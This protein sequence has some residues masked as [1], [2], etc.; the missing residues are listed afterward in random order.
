MAK[1]Q[2]ERER[3]QYIRESKFV[4]T[5]D[6]EIEFGSFVSGAF[7]GSVGFSLI[8]LTV[9]VKAGLQEGDGEFADKW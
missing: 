3:D 9:W 4:N 6:W 2:R 5:L 8:Y 7:F 1:E